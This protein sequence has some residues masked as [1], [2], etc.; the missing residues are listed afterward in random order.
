MILRSVLLL[1]AAGAL[2]GLSAMAQTSP[3]T[4]PAKPHPGAQARFAQ[5]D[6]DHDGFIEKSEATGRVA[7]NFDAI[8]TDHDGKLS[9]D[10]LRAALKMA[11]GKAKTAPAPAQAAAPEH[12]APERGAKAKM[13][14]MDT[15]GDGRIS[16]AEFTAREKALFDKLDAN[17]DGYLDASEMPKGRKLKGGKLGENSFGAGTWGKPGEGAASSSAAS[18]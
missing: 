17:H 13:S 1:T 7:K 18:Q 15:D 16:Y 8:D 4:G 6:A 9:P 5:M 3:D 11:A 2:L 10:E 12:G 14:A